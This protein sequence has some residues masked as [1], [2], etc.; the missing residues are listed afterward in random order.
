MRLAK[1][2]RSSYPCP[3]NW[4]NQDNC[5]VKPK[6]RYGTFK[7]TNV[8]DAA[9]GRFN[10]HEPKVPPVVTSSGMEMSLTAWLP[11]CEPVMPTASR[12]ISDAPWPGG[13]A[14]LLRKTV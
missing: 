10:G 5:S 3:A 4:D 8:S 9:G 11:V 7:V 1:A 13:L 2:D 12:S 14:N 6:K